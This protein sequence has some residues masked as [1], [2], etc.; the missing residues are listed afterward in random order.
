MKPYY[1]FLSVCIV[2]FTLF[3]Q[4]RGQT[5]DIR[6][7]V[8][9]DRTE[10]PI[11]NANVRL[12]Q[13]NQQTQSDGTFIFSDIPYGMYDI[14]VEKYN[15]NS[16]NIQIFIDSEDF[17]LYH[18]KLQSVHDNLES[19]SNET[20]VLLSDLENDKSNQN[21]SAMLLSRQDE[22]ASAAGYNLGF[23]RFQPRGYSSEYY[24]VHINGIRMNQAL[25]NRPVWSEWG[26]LNDATR[27]QESVQ[28]LQPAHFS[29]GNIGGTSNINTRP[30]VIPKQQKFSYAIGNRSYNNRLMYTYSSGLLRNNWAFAV[31]ISK[32][33]AEE[34]Y[35]EGTWYDAWSGFFSS[36]KKFNS[37]HS[38]VIS[39]FASPY[40]RAMQGPA[41]QEVYDL[42]GNNFYNPNWGWQMGEKRNARVRSMMNPTA[43]I[44]HYWNVS[45][46]LRI[47]NALGFVYNTTGTTAL[48]WY[49]APDPRPDYYRYLPSYQKD[50]YISGLVTSIWQQD[51]SKSQID[52][53]RL[54]Q[55]NYLQNLEKKQAKYIIENRKHISRTLTIHPCVQYSFSDNFKYSGG[56]EFQTYRGEQYKQI[57]DLLGGNFWLDIDQFAERDFAGDTA[58]LIN[59]LQNPDKELKEGDVYGYHYFLNK[60]LLNQW[61]MLNFYTNKFDIFAG[62]NIGFVQYW[63]E[64]KMKNGRYPDNS[65]GKSEVYSFNNLSA[66]GGITYKI[67]G[68][69]LLKLQAG[70]FSIA[71]A[72]S[73][74]FVVPTI[75]N[76]YL[77]TLNNEQ[78]VSSDITYIHSDRIVSGKF[79]LYHTIFTDQTS[80]TFFY[81]D[82]LRTFVNLI[83]TGIDKVHQGIETGL[84]VKITNQ[85][86]WIGYTNLGNYVYT[87]R[88][89][90]LISYVNGASP[91]TS[92]TIYSKYFFDA[93]T[94]QY[95]AT[96]GLKYNSSKYWFCNLFINYIDKNYLSFNP[97]RR[98]EK[99][100][101]NLGIDDPLIAEITEQYRLDAG[102]TI[103]VS[104]GKSWKINNQ[105][106]MIHLSVNNV[107][108]NTTIRTGGFEQM[109]FDFEN[110]QINKFPPKYF[111]AYG[112]NY[113]IMISYRF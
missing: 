86:K 63:R 58:I 34:G 39:A 15:Y 61:S 107:L 62:Y 3:H 113:F 35:V 110:K 92:K 37:Q 29:F 14:I 100:I 76:K 53:N 66:K 64:G 67:T 27:N 87:S 48:N 11:E 9:D 26:G 91:D 88:P 71:P 1:F 73:D 51:E 82:D 10:M 75:S 36:E 45:K 49:D 98:T 84:S 96:T 52:W 78:I 81:H 112:R 38:I 43:I 55:V 103:D 32:R 85:L 46:K 65:L 102:Y 57:E 90:A 44:N 104:F 97:E 94:P 6:G 80:S 17:V 95:G 19:Q 21:V 109:R 60:H 99:A 59:N 40:K 72:L 89:D 111:Y 56:F 25:T 83:Q 7:T 23:A 5:I 33:W 20:V 42:M 79:S 30:T 70:Y 18:L 16:L 31:N 54:Y 28:G 22:F 4:L 50:N 2:F 106:I 69:D 93:T 12:N 47:N 8:I 77:S 101:E 108:N 24:D 13:L 41:T 68:K 74:V 105:F